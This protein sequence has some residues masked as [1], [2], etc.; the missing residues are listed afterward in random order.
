MSPALKGT[1]DEIAR[2]V[3][4]IY[5][6]VVNV[7]RLK[8]CVIVN[9]MEVLLSKKKIKKKLENTLF[10]FLKNTYIVFQLILF[11]IHVNI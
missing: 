11:E 7:T 5:K 9:V 6:Y 4:T 2:R 1:S 10:I 3:V 8:S